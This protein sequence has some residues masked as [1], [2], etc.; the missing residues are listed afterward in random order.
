MEAAAAPALVAAGMAD[1][2]QEL[3][4]R[5]QGEAAAATGFGDDPAATAPQPRLADQVAE[6]DALYAASPASER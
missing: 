6:L 3:G 4:G 5:G 2:E 1:V